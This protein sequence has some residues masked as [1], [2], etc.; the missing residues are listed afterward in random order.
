MKMEKKIFTFFYAG[1]EENL[2]FFSG[3]AQGKFFHNLS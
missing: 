1:N 2:L 3:E